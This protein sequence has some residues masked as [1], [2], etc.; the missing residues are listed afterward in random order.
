MRT[1][2][3]SVALTSSLFAFDMG[4]MMSSGA[5]I[6]SSMLSSEKST[7]S[8]VDILTSSLGISTTQ[9]AGG[10]GAILS[11]ATSKMSKSDVEKLSKDIPSIS[12]LLSSPLSDSAMSIMKHESVASQFEALGLS[13]DMVGKFV[14]VILDY[15]NSEAGSE[16]MNALKSAIT[17]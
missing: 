4:S 7:S 8:L 1:L 6:A 15:V 12:S 9:A 5:N 3:I 17:D 13:A 14:P 16:M 11:D 2:L 10:A